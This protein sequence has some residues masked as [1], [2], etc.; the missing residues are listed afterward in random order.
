MDDRSRQLRDRLSV[1]LDD[2][3]HLVGAGPKV[4][5]RERALRDALLLDPR[6]VLEE[7]DQEV[8]EAIIEVT[9]GR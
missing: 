2:C 9:G 8:V 1:P 3:N 7:Q 5:D 4:G 6:T